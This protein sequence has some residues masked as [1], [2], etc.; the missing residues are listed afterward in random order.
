MVQKSPGH[1]QA[2]DAG[3]IAKTDVYYVSIQLD[4]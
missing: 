4:G 1:Q 2:L 3:F